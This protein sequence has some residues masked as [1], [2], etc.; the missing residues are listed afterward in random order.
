M[1]SVYKTNLEAVI[2]TK[3]V[4][5]GLMPVYTAINVMTSV[6]LADMVLNLKDSQA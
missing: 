5:P 6:A 1:Y 2:N 4:K 3:A